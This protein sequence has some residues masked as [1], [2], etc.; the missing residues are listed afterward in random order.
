M[1]V[2]RAAPGTTATTATTVLYGNWQIDNLFGGGGLDTL[3]GG[4]GN[5]I[6]E[7]GDGADSV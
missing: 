4:K 7:G 5:D 6:F 1:P 3:Q 2:P